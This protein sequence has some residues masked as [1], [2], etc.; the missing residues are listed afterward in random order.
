MLI[1]A[2]LRCCSCAHRN[3][4]SDRRHNEPH[5]HPM[6]GALACA[7][8][9]AAKPSISGRKGEAY[10]RIVVA[11]V[12]CLDTQGSPPRGVLVQCCRETMAASEEWL[13]SPCVLECEPVGPYSG[14]R[15]SSS[16]LAFGIGGFL[17][18]YDTEYVRGRTDWM[19]TWSFR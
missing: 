3:L 19:L 13:L 15:G 9:L 10:I 17:R 18:L 8:T 14:F 11:D 1:A 7:C 4:A 6:E 16:A 12:S 5:A 2:T